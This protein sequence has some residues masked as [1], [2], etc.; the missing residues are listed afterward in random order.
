[1][2]NVCDQISAGSRR[3]LPICEIATR[4]S[5][6]SCAVS[7][8]NY[9]VTELRRQRMLFERFTP[10]QARA[11]LRTI[12]TAHLIAAAFART[13]CQKA[14]GPTGHQPRRAFLKWCPEEDSNLHLLQDWYLKPARLP[15]PPSGR[16][17]LLGGA[18][19]DVNVHSPPF[20]YWH[21]APGFKGGCLAFDTLLG[22]C[23][24]EIEGVCRCP[25]RFSMKPCSMTA[26]TV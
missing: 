18:P 2:P 22:L 7:P 26:G 3:R 23:G 19:A 13:H 9:R 14:K 8:G 6:R 4:S 10:R 25:L 24:A 11:C 21:R 15:I 5:A 12:A 20:S 17:G 16:G 1:M